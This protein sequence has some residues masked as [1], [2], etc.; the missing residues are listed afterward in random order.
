MPITHGAGSS[1]TVIS[2]HV[3]QIKQISEVLSNAKLLMDF[4]YSCDYKGNQENWKRLHDIL[5]S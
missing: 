2:H 4:C 1:G 5:C 3:F